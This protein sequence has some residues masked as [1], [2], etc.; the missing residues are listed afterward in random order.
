MSPAY[1][2]IESRPP[3]RSEEFPSLRSEY[4][5]MQS[6]DQPVRVRFAPSP[7]GLLHIGGLRTALYNYLFARRHGGVFIL[8]IE[9][10]DQERYVDGAEQDILDSL[11]W[12]GIGYDEGPGIGGP[13][14]PYHQSA[15]REYYRQYAEQLLEAEH[16][17]IAFD[18]HEELEAMR[19]RFASAGA[20]GAYN[21]RTRQE[22]SNS[23][24]LPPDEVERRLQSGQPHVVRL[25]VEPGESVH[26]ND[27]IRDNVSF[28]TEQ[29]DDQVL[30]KSDGL[31]TYHLANVVDDHEMG[32]THVIR[33][34]EWL[35]S[36]PKHILLYEYLGWKPPTM[37]HL[38]LILSPNGGKLSKRNAEKMGIPVSVRQYRDA[39]YEPDA[40][41]NFLAFLGW[42]PGTDDEIF[43]LE[44]LVGQFSL[45]R[46][47]SAGT[48]F[49]LDKLNWYNGQYLRMRTPEELA[50]EA[51][52]AVEAAGYSA[53]QEYL[54]GVARLMR[55]RLAFA[56]DLATDADYFFLEPEA[57]DEAGVA[58][59]WKED[60]PALLAA[61]ADRLEGA[62]E[63]DEARAEEMLKAVA[64]EQ[65][66][67][68]GR[69]IHPVRLALSGRTA[70]P[71][72]Y[73]MMAV[74]GREACVR[75][76]RRA[77]ERLD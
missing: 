16:A 47:G 34:E 38:P 10:T 4:I 69:V 73:D 55:E 46:V 52:P 56:K 15:R 1:T 11:A 3:R 9:D 59:R 21:A 53:S 45:E 66:A 67:G 71:G 44:G 20:P 17:Y 39:G 29:I 33:G 14:E 68:A 24:S 19:E 70:G 8:R 30:I 76:I 32:V 6:P 27:A 26:F 28:E 23:L 13:H 49:S 48:Q 74:L 51:R 58:K 61:Y 60:S 65:G 35:P 50:A 64:E 41:I 42:N 62:D 7:T 77:V 75:R 22:M 25:K 5:R 72:L 54:E 57:Y 63:F 18:T 43:S 36:T 2:V 37:A 40:L 12:A 31:P